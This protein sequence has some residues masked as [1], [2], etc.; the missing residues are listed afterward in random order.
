MDDLDPVNPERLK[1]AHQVGQ[2]TRAVSTHVP[3]ARRARHVETGS[4]CFSALDPPAQ[5]DELCFPSYSAR[6]PDRR[7]PIREEPTEDRQRVQRRA[8]SGYRVD[9][10]VDEPGDE[11]S[12]API[13][14]ASAGGDADAA[15]VGNLRD[16][17]TFDDDA[18][19]RHAR[20]TLDVDD[21]D[22]A[23]DDGGA[24]A[25]LSLKR[26]RAKAG[27]EKKPAGE[28]SAQATLLG[29]DLARLLMPP[30]AGKG[31]SPDA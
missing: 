16:P 8:R 20:A 6:L 12:T 15:R 7:D 31:D 9:V 18:L 2:V 27:N 17:V 26:A 4:D 14:H 29:R 1:P 11:V 25:L 28:R 23:D 30:D 10:R 24:F 21:G 19:A 5:R 22:V 13:D 3:R